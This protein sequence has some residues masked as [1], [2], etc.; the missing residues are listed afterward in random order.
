MNSTVRQK[1]I[2]YRSICTDD[3]DNDNIKHNKDNIKYVNLFKNLR[4]PNSV[5]KFFKALFVYVSFPVYCKCFL[6]CSPC[7]D[8]SEA[9][10][11]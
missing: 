3:D 2:V 1:P 6:Y 7:G 10:T 8:P 11:R 4:L 9:D 5:D